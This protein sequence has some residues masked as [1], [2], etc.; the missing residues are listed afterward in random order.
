MCLNEAFTIHFLLHSP[1]NRHSQEWKKT[2]IPSR[3]HLK[4]HYGLQLQRKKVCAFVRTFSFGRRMYIQYLFSKN[5][6]RKIQIPPQMH[7]RYKQN[8]LIRHLGSAGGDLISN[9]NKFQ[10]KIGTGGVSPA[11]VCHGIHIQI[12]EERIL[13]SLFLLGYSWFALSWAVFLLNFSLVELLANN[14][15]RNVFCD[16]SSIYS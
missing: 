12:Q 14:L 8:V 16:V 10:R 7:S 2:F 4:L 13:P 11:D 5:K 6:E 3:L 1:E 15:L 9:V